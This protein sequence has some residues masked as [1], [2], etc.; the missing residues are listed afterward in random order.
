MWVT[1][2]QH[3]AI[4]KHWAIRI[5]THHPILCHTISIIINVGFTVIHTRASVWRYDMH[6]PNRIIIIL[7]M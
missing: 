5:T 7:L 2:G 4:E 6:I 3:R 1:V